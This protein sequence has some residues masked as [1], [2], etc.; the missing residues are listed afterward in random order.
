[1]SSLL[2]SMRTY[3]LTVTAITAMVGDRISIDHSDQGDQEPRLVLFDI[4]SI[5]GHTLRGADGLPRARVQIDC[6]GTSRQQADELGELVRMALDGF[7]GQ[8]DE[9]SID[10]CLMQTN[11]ADFEPSPGLDHHRRYVRHQDYFIYHH[12]PKPA[13]I[14]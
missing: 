5:Q 10:S 12:E 13:L 1:M 7:K 8:W 3:L 6:I 2:P 11:F 9:Q 4:S 14:T